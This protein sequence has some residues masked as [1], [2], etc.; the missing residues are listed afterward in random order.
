MQSWDLTL[1]THHNSLSPICST[2]PSELLAEVFAYLS[3]S[4][5]PGPYFMTRSLRRS[6]TRAVLGWIKVTHVCRHWRNVALDYSSLWGNISYEIGPKW[7]KLMMERAKAA[8]LTLKQRMRMDTQRAADLGE[9]QF[10]SSRMSQMEEL[11]LYGHP[12]DLRKIMR[13]LQ[14]KAAP[15]LKTLSLRCIHHANVPAHLMLH[16]E[17]GLFSGGNTPRLRT[18]IFKN[19]RFSWTSPLLSNLTYLAIYQDK[20]VSLFILFRLLIEAFLYI[21][22]S[23]IPPPTVDELLSVLGNLP[24]L[25]SLSLENSIPSYPMP[26]N[27]ANCIVPSRPRTVVLPGLALLYLDGDHFDCLSLLQ[28]LSFPPYID[29]SIRLQPSSTPAERPHLGIIQEIANRVRTLSQDRLLPIRKAFVHAPRMA[30]DSSHEPLVQLTV[31][32]PRRHIHSAAD[33]SYCTTFS[34]EFNLE[35]DIEDPVFWE[36]EPIVT[37]FMRL[38]P[39]DG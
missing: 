27:P 28:S 17:D 21:R 20:F 30:P 16:L 14:N 26:R 39:L 1:R 35:D 24:Q 23:P 36:I 4:E 12:V 25:E 5:K 38:M 15:R 6:P 11:E 3:L 19:C 18:V 34:L 33:K 13:E 7:T 29:V 10:I 2:F 8:P 9:P 22:R 37:D 32:L 31:E